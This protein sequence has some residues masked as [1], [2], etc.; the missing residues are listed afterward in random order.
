[1][2][3]RTTPRPV[4]QSH[5]RLSVNSLYAE[6]DARR[7]RADV[8]W[9]ALSAAEPHLARAVAL[10]RRTL[11]AQFDLLREAA[12]LVDS[13]PVLSETAVLSHLTGGLPVLRANIGPL[14][15]D[16]LTPVMADL[17]AAIT[18]ATGYA[19]ARR[20]AD[21]L[22]ARTVD[23][24]R[25]L[26]L[27]YQ[28]DQDGVGQL[29]AEH[30]LVV[31]MLWLLGDLVIAPIVHLQQRAALRE[32][33]PASPVREGLERWDHGYCPACGSWP[34]LAEIFFGERLLRCAFC[35]CTW[36]QSRQQCTFCGE[37]GD[38][39]ATLVP[40]RQQIGRRLEL[41]R[42]CGGFL[43]TLDVERVTPFPLLA[44]EDLA[45]SDLDQAALHHGFK[46]LALKRL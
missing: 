10:Q 23:P 7:Q 30:A 2:A 44:I 26:A 18:S 39:F 27:V 11:G 31:D 1:M 4:G 17:G 43:K 22:G 34:A 29:A 19:A 41:C 13:S 36:R 28:R 14:P 9:T 3:G 35:A 8:R 37:R 32:A 20:V 45:S 21:A 12:P 38:A 42:T 46:R 40:E 33:E 6:I 5:N 15:V 16:M 24:A 25:V